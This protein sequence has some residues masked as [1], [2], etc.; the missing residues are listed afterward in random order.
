MVGELTIPQRQII[1]GIEQN[2]QWFL[3]T[4][5]I[6]EILSCSRK[7]ALFFIRGLIRKKWLA[8]LGNNHYLL[9]KTTT[10]KT[11]I[12][13]FDPLIIGSY[14]AE[15]YYFS[16]RTA[17]VYYGFYRPTPSPVYL[18]STYSRS[19]VT[20]NGVDYRIVSL[21]PR[22]FFGFQKI[23][24]D[25]RDVFLADKEKAMVDCLEKF[26]YADGI[27]PVIVQLKQ[28]IKALD[29]ERMVEYAVQ[30][31]SSTVI[32]RLGYL[33][34]QLDVPFDDEFMLSHSS[35]TLYYFDPYYSCGMRPVRNEKWNLMVNIPP[36]LFEKKE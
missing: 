20:I 32:Q 16:Y 22:K 10:K 15:P 13:H 4:S 19:Q 8:A 2:K 7:Q 24:I 3:Q 25:H 29:I 31:H 35:R 5:D 33:L 30:M 34:E 27:V 36:T 6:S 9:L 18:V 17:M 14:L 1:E 26:W 21:D 12:P 11:K 23:S 28:Q